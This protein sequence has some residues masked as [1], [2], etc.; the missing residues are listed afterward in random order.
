MTDG[1]L[2]A[3]ALLLL[4]LIATATVLLVVHDAIRW[5]GK[6]RSTARSLTAAVCSCLGVLALG[7]LYLPIHASSTGAECLFFPL[8]EV[9]GPEGSL[10]AVRE[11]PD[12]IDRTSSRECDALARGRVAVSSAVLVGSL[13][14]YVVVRRRAK[15]SLWGV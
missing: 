8:T 3:I 5:R 12:E 11:P 9:L 10:E 2:P 13:I 1:L 14:C 7:S 15:I 4:V 6:A